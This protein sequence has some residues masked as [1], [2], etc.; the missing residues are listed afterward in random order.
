[1]LS[2][3]H[4][5]FEQRKVLYA[6]KEE[7]TPALGQ[8][9]FAKLNTG[10]YSADEEALIMRL[11]IKK[12]YLNKRHGQYEF[13]KKVPV[14]VANEIPRQMRNL[15]AGMATLLITYASYGLING[16]IYIPGKRTEGITFAGEP[17]LA[18]FAACFCLALAL[19]VT[20]VDHYD[21]RDNEYL[22]DIAEKVL[23]ALSCLFFTWAC[24]WDWSQRSSL[25]S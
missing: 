7:I 2:K 1:M 12:S 15:W 14:Y 6:G 9:L 3:L 22:Y 5:Y 20:V 21:K 16:E 17:V 11:L 23:W 10:Y 19:L 8:K 13:S 18:V 25:L 24:L 4:F